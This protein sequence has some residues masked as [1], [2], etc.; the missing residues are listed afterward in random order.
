MFKSGNEKKTCDPFFYVTENT[1][2]QGTRHEAGCTLQDTK[3]PSE[4]PVSLNEGREDELFRRE[5]SSGS[6]P[7]NCQV[8]SNKKF[9]GEN[10]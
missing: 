4:L 5:A 2:A 1:Y 8:N 3:T 9:K 7:V 10:I 6:N